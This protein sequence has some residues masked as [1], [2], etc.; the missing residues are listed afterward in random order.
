VFVEI[1]FNKLRKRIFANKLLDCKKH[2]I[3]NPLNPELHYKLGKIGSIAGDKVMAYAQFKTAVSLGYYQKECNYDWHLLRKNIV[4]LGSVEHNL[5]FRMK[6]I[7]DEIKKN[8]L[9]DQP[10]SIMDVGGGNGLLAQFLPENA[11][12]CLVEPMVNGLDS[13]VLP[14]PKK[15]FSV[16]A[17]CHVFEHIPFNERNNF[18]DKLCEQAD[19]SVIL[20]NPFEIDKGMDKKRLEL[21]W[22]ITAA[23][24]A[25]EHIKCSLPTLRSIKEFAKARNKSISI[26]PSGTSALSAAMVFVEY[27]GKKAF[28]FGDFERIT[29]FFNLLPEDIITN[30]RSPNVHIVTL[31]DRLDAKKIVK[32][33]SN[34]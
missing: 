13:N 10:I 11:E 21:F 7:A 1:I 19:D 25:K 26:T 6:T 32:T 27:F 33:Y 14:I 3:K 15:K 17:A 9:K 16:V 30:E 28:K 4:E 18:L 24:W 23:K 29:R 8:H 2:L 20:V 12:Y 31:R 22:E 34:C 5:F